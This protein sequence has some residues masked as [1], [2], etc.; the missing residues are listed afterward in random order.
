MKTYTLEEFATMHNFGISQLRAACY[1]G[2]IDFVM[3][4]NVPKQRGGAKRK[5][6][7]TDTPKTMAQAERMKRWGRCEPKKKC[8]Y[9][10]LSNGLEVRDDILGKTMRGD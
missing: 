7:I 3:D 8:S 4:Y 2:T 6:L 9:L 1:R 5:M 10:I